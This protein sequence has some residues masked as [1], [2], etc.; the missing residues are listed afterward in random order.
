[1]YYR[2]IIIYLVTGI[3]IVSID[4]IV[5]VWKYIL[6]GIFLFIMLI[7]CAESAKEQQ[8][9]S[10]KSDDNNS[11]DV[12]TKKGYMYCKKCVRY[13]A[14]EDGEIPENFNKNCYCG[15]KL[16]YY[17]TLDEIFKL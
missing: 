17:E 9:S 8:Q 6:L 1:M 12:N 7:L 14:L 4:M 15:G 2:I 16:K 10:S 11:L 5:A 3:A 13:Y